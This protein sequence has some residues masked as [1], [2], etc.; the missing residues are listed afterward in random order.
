MEHV[1]YK[2]QNLFD[3]MKIIYGCKYIWDLNAN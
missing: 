1:S 3:Y 2:N